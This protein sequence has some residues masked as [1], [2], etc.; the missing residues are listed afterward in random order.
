LTDAVSDSRPASASL[1]PLTKEQ[2]RAHLRVLHVIDRLDVGGT[3]LGIARV[4][5]G[6]SGKNFTHRVCAIRGFN[7]D[8]VKTQALAGKV[9]VAGEA[10]PGFQFLVGRLAR[11]MREFRPHV[12]HSRNWGGIEGIAA[13]RLTRV[14]LAIHSEHGYEVDMLAG[15]PMHRRAMRHIAYTAADIVFTVSVELRNYH[16][17][18]A[19]F[20]A[21]RIRVVPNGVDTAKFCPRLN[22]RAEMRK[23]LGLPEDCIAIGSVGRL[24]AI[25]DYATLLQATKILVESG[26]PV[27]LLLAGSGP[28]LINYRRFV[29]TSPNLANRVR[30]LGASTDVPALLNALDVFVLPSLSEGMSNTLL[31]AMAV[32][33]PIVAS[34]VGGNPEIIEDECSGLLFKAGDVSELIA[35]LKA[36][37]QNP[38]LRQKLGQA[39]R[40]RAES[41]LS[42]E[43]MIDSYHDLYLSVGRRRK[44][45]SFP[46]D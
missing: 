18:Q 25:K 31:E 35:R 36:L 44:V 46:Q 16:A 10:K 19:W 22:E 24:V 41:K 38:A 11:V 27:C 20:P 33:L 34:R 15:L 12:V 4:I 13:A 45:P 7:E 39:A 29:G 9:C 37:V 1:P 28:E 23:R 26:L 32:G 3:E 6:L 14:P 21:E 17:G 43:R 42:L 5:R 30:F 40:K 8:F 2:S